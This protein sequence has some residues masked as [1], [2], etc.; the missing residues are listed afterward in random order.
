MNKHIL[1]EIGLSEREIA[2]YTSLVKIGSTTTGPL[3][4]SSDVQNAK[5]YETLEKLIKKG[6]VTFVIKGKT[7][8]FQSTNPDNILNIYKEKEN[9]LKE[10][11]KELK[12]LQTEKE[13]EIETKVYEGFNALK[14]A[15]FELYKSNGKNSEYY[16][17][18]IGEQLGSENLV[19][20]WSQVLH[21]QQEMKIKIKTLP[22]IK[23]KNIF[24]KHYKNYKLIN[25]KY[26]NQ[27]FPTG[28]F[29]FK[30]RILNVVWSEKPV[31]FLIK[32]KENT[33]RWTKFF[34]QEWKK[35]KS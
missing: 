35:A 19:I 28:I 33:E 27:E 24:E 15:F 3:V 12:N 26:T 32:S 11:I 4:K 10:T 18:P 7:K 5:I 1:K 8:Y 16:V 9:S 14:S 23:W 17:F 30:D 20:F 21:K 31:G 22:N 25:I 6:L 2:V 29:I 34:K 13:V